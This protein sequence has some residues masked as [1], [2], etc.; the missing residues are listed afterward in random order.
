MPEIGLK[1]SCGKVT[2]KT[3]NINS[4]SG[5]RITCCCYDC[6][7]FARYLDQEDTVLDEYGGT[8]IFQM[9]ISNLKITKGE[10]H[11]SCLRLSTKGLYRW[12]TKCCNTPIGN[13]MGPSMPFIGVIHNFMNHTSSRDQDLGKNRGYI[14]TKNAKKK[15]PNNLSESAFRINLGTITKLIYWKI[16]GLNTPSS[17]FDDSGKPVAKPKVLN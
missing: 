7:S 4:G 15:I 9:P 17:F 1:C 13:T 16:K 10:E 8:D 11:I 6:Q 3:S 12:Y 2:G 14:E 5:T